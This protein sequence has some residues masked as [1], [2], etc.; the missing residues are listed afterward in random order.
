MQKMDSMFLEQMTMNKSVSSDLHFIHGGPEIRDQTFG[1]T[2]YSL[3]LIDILE[4]YYKPTISTLGLLLNSISVAVFLHTD[5]NRLAI[6]HYLVAIGIID[7]FYLIAL[8]IPWLSRYGVGLFTTMG[9]CQIV[10]YVLH[11]SSFLACWYM[12]LSIMQRC[13]KLYSRGLRRRFESVLQAKFIIVLVAVF[14]G[15]GFLHVT[16]THGVVDVKRRSGSSIVTT[17]KCTILPED[18]PQMRD[19]KRVEL[20]FSFVFPWMVTFSFLFVRLSQYCTCPHWICPPSSQTKSEIEGSAVLANPVSGAITAQWSVR[21]F[22]HVPKPTTEN[23]DVI[24]NVPCLTITAI[25]LMS[26]LPYLSM[27]VIVW[28]FE[29]GEEDDFFLPLFRN[30]YLLHFVSKFFVYFLSV[31]EFRQGILLALGGLATQEIK[32]EIALQT[33]CLPRVSSKTRMIDTTDL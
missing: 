10:L 12:A 32:K 6:S 5:L 28:F 16:W 31:S 4:T 15:V 18:A 29:N 7:N 11:F 33:K 23:L 14:A 17:T 22:D 19:L 26:S 1:H 27:M 20:L 3:K 25:F 13:A 8:I 30:V 24:M 9:V 21:T 2:W